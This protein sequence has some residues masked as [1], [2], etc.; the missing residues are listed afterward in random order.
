MGVHTRA[1]RRGHNV[2]S[3]V[4]GE[5]HRHRLQAVCVR[6]SPERHFWSG[7]SQMLKACSTF[8]VFLSIGLR[9]AR[10]LV[11][12]AVG[13]GKRAVG[14]GGNGGAAIGGGSRR[15]RGRNLCEVGASGISSRRSSAQIEQYWFFLG[16]SLLTNQ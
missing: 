16:S 9:M 14:C 2:T 4:S 11:T 6:A 7:T 15:R 8:F 5:F 10:D 1:G 13:F 3:S 12:R